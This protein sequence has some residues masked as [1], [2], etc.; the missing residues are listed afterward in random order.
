MTQKV[1]QPT[2][3]RLRLEGWGRLGEALAY[4]DDQPVFVFGGIPG[5]E[6]E[7]EVLYRGR[8]YL[9]ARVAQ[10]LEPSPHRATPPCPHFGTCT[11][12][13]WQHIDYA[14]TLEL[15]RQMVVDA[16]VRV[17]GFAKP[18]VAKTMAAPN[19]YGYRNHARFTVGPQG[20]LGFVN[21][22]TRRFV[23]VN[24]CL[25][26]PD[27]INKMLGQLQGRCAET[28]Q[29]SVRYSVGTNEF[30]IQPTLKNEEV[31]LP[32]G[33]KHLNE[34]LNGR[35]FR[36]AS[37]SFFQVNVIQAERMVEVV[38]RALRLSGREFIVDAYAGVGT[39]AI[40]LAPQCRRVIAI[41]ESGPAVE[42]GQANGAGIDNLEFRQ[43]KVE[44]VLGAIEEQP[45][46]VILDP[47]RVG[48]HLGVLEALARLHPKKVVYV[49]C[50]PTTL[51]R[52]LKV[53]CAQGFRLLRVQP[54]DMFP[55]THHVECVATLSWRKLAGGVNS[56]AQNLV[57]ASSSPRRSELLSSLGLEFQ[58]EPPLLNEE[59]FPEETPQSLV[60]RLALA[61]AHSVAASRRKGLVIGA[62]SV[63]VADDLIL[64]K[65]STVAQARDTL[66]RLR[67][68]TH[69]VF[70]GVAVVDAA[71]GQWRVTSRAT[72]VTMRE[73]SSQEIETYI[74]SGEPM[75]KAGAYGVQDTAFRPAACVQGCYSNVVGLPL[76][77]LAQLLDEIGDKRALAPAPHLVEGCSDCPV[78][79]RFA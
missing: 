40:L 12:C 8:R 75:D 78:A 76:C 15:K 30:L 79:G 14:H 41:E 26:M 57:L 61:K 34:Q 16:L 39:F 45:D 43:A 36:V 46:G 3:L 64:G 68:R 25:L 2:F 7:V 49:S 29:V 9:A 55:Q 44:D 27:Q 5:E 70:S 18:P 72:A 50:D 20:S 66:V 42:D 54:I 19:E 13:Q 4:H 33:Q 24:K 59:P 37:P 38:S 62:D 47:P 77:G 21:R 31:A 56:A 63:V 17:G 74:A 35:Q 69:Q 73:Y 51:A 1:Y 67:G 22:Q 32:T 11:G 52:D 48:C 10:V 28:T 53:L 60:E 58:V 65:P 71:T 23:P 6:V